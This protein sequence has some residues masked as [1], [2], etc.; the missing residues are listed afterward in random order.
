MP[1][2]EENTGSAGKAYRIFF[3]IWPDNDAQK[4]LAGLA[5]QLRLESLCGGRK[6]KTENIHLTLVFVGKV[7]PDSL[8]ALYDAGDRIK[9]SGSP[10]FDLVI[11]EIHYWK[12]NHIVY[13]APGKVPQALV[14][15]ERALRNAISAAG[16]PLE[17]RT[18][19]PHITLMRNAFCPTLPELAEPIAWRVREWTLVKSE[20]TSNGSV[21]TPIRCWP[22]ETSNKP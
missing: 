10:A 12:H 9:Q 20:Q 14:N 4:Q 19:A 22:L 8:K 16:F 7:Y 5:K 15:L 6:I 21:Y 1:T 2:T 13:V 3:A 17:Q 18:Y 11:D